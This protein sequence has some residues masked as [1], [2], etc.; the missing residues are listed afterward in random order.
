MSGRRACLICFQ[1]ITF[2][3]FLRSSAGAAQWF[4]VCRSLTGQPLHQHARARTSLP[5]CRLRLTSIG[6]CLVLCLENDF[7]L[8]GIG[9]E[10][11]L[12]S[13]RVP[14]SHQP[15][16]YALSR[17]GTQKYVALWLQ[18]WH[19]YFRPSFLP[20]FRSSRVGLPKRA[21]RGRRKVSRCNAV[22]TST[23]A[24]A[25][26]ARERAGGR[27]RGRLP[28]LAWRHAGKEVR[29]I[30]S[31]HSSPIRKMEDLIK[32]HNFFLIGGYS[33]NRFSGNYLSSLGVPRKPTWELSLV[34]SWLARRVKN[35]RKRERLLWAGTASSF[36][37]LLG[38]PQMNDQDWE[39]RGEK[40]NLP[41]LQIKA[42]K[43][44]TQ[45]LI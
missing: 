19:C 30:V 41:N 13:R 20:S 17:L 26:R 15:R 32:T 25:A 23:K 36:T 2:N 12:K 37:C 11:A 31:Q 40:E 29:A 35:T 38:A 27:G 22:K 28:C 6:D 24:S 8:G 42:R 39:R 3:F 18:L 4:A 7:K 16:L 44:E 9:N 34:V 21:W 1:N 5:P 14:I 43:R 45:L 33:M 10:M